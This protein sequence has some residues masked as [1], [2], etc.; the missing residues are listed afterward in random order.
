MIPEIL[1][2]ANFEELT[3]FPNIVSLLEFF[4]MVQYGQL[5]ANQM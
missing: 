1:I 2:K 4:M 3:L 5:A